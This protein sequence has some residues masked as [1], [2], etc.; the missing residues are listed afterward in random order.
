M[1]LK[2]D[3]ILQKM[4][5]KIVTGMQLM[6]TKGMDNVTVF[7][8]TITPKMNISPQQFPML[9]QLY[10]YITGTSL[11]KGDLLKTAFNR[12]QF[13]S[14]EISTMG[15]HASF[16]SLSSNASFKEKVLCLLRNMETRPDNLT[17]RMERLEAGRGSP[18]PRY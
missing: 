2:D 6:T 3:I 9:L 17:A 18:I 11:K 13:Q 7:W 8:R 5:G 10:I 1:S 14:S 15:S 12:Q 4:R 16:P